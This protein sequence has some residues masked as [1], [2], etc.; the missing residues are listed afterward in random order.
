M[1]MQ[2]LA[3]TQPLHLSHAVTSPYQELVAF[4]L[5]HP[6]HVNLKTVEPPASEKHTKNRLRET[7]KKWAKE[8]FAMPCL[9]LRAGVAE[10]YLPLIV[11]TT[12]PYKGGVDAPFSFPMFQLNEVDVVWDPGAHRTIMVKDLLSEGFREY[13]H[14]QIH[15]PYR[16]GLKGG[17]GNTYSLISGCIPTLAFAVKRTHFL[18]TVVVAQCREDRFLAIMNTELLMNQ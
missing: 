2:W 10:G 3:R 14:H 8:E 6:T 1:Y 16:S 17:E 9:T 7:A 18:W 12:S 13:L 11:T 15:D 4:W 5:A